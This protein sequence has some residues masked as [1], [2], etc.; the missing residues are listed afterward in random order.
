MHI[1]SAGSLKGTSI[2]NPTNEDLGSVK[3]LMLDVGQ[4][5]IAYAVVSFGGILGIGDK[6]FAVPWGSFTLDTEQERLVLDMPREKL[7]NAEGFD[8]DNWPDASDLTFL[9]SIYEYYGHEPYWDAEVK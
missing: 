8:K 3:E 2:V 4:G 6:L 1:L 5:R 9:Q 7:E